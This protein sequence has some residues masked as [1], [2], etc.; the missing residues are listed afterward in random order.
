MRRGPSGPMSN[1]FTCSVSSVP[2][3]A[4]KASAMTLVMRCGLTHRRTSGYQMPPLMASDRAGSISRNSSPVFSSTRTPRLRRM[5]R[6][7]CERA[8]PVSL[9]NAC[10]RPVLTIISVRPISPSTASKASPA[11]DSNAARASEMAWTLRCREFMAKRMNHGMAFGRYRHRTVSG[12]IGSSSILG[13]LLIIPGRLSGGTEAKPILPE[14]PS[15]APSPG[16]PLSI[17]VTANPSRWS[18]QA[19]QTPT[20]PAPMT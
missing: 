6:A 20:M 11:C 10:I 3:A 13:T 8:T 1:P 7:Y 5:S 14:L 17:S 9:S 16:A 19:Q 2:P 4:T 18:H 15:D 12:C